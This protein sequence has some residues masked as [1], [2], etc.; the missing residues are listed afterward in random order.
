M[1]EPISSSTATATVATVTFV[2]LLAGLQASVVLGA[3]A[4]A[5]VFVVTAADLGP[6]RKVALFA[7]SMIAG[8]LADGLAASLLSF[9]LPERIIIA[10]GVGALVASA[11]TVKLLQALIRADSDTLLNLLR[12]GKP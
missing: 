11:V 9:A 10:P 8:V 3:F 7:A 6:F 5:V 4:G 1:P 12:R 2:S